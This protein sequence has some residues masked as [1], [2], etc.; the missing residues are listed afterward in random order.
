MLASH[1][2]QII[3][4]GLVFLKVAFYPKVT[5]FKS[6][7]LEQLLCTQVEE[8]ISS[9]R[10]NGKALGSVEEAKGRINASTEI[11]FC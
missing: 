10:N 9:I 11:A 7:L 2:E 5:A 8:I 3:V 1:W 6:L 4:L